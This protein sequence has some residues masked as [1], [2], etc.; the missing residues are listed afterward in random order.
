[1]EGLYCFTGSSG[2]ACSAFTGNS[3]NYTVW[4]KRF[5]HFSNNVLNSLKSVLKLS[6][7]D[8]SD[9]CAVCHKAKQ[10]CEPFPL[11]SHK[12][13]ALFDLVHAD[14]W[15]P[16]SVESYDGSKYF[17]T[18]VDDFSRATW[19][20]LMRSKTKVRELIE[21]FCAL[22]KTQFKSSMKVFRSDNG[23]EFINSSVNNLFRKL[24]IIHQISCT[25]TPQQNGIAE[26]KHKHLL[27]VARALM[28]QSACPLQFWFDCILT[29]IFLSI[30]H[31]VLF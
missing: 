3:V 10:N 15:G 18:L 4:H 20:F 7:C 26:R 25:D 16:F 27:N 1:M 19:L 21:H 2:Y 24:G 9:S 14:V 6:N 28:F 23:T 22:I 12:S 11:S 31:L 17:V 29:A 8:V 13:I 5:G 30:E